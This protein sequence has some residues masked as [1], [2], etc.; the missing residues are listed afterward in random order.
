MGLV[1]C[2]ALGIKLSRKRAED[3][4]TF[5][6]VGTIGSLTK[7]TLAYV[8]KHSDILQKDKYLNK[9][10]EEGKKQLVKCYFDC[11]FRPRISKFEYEEEL[12]SCWGGLTSG[13]SKHTYERAAPD[14]VFVCI[15]VNSEYPAI[16]VKGVPCGPGLKER[17]PGVEGV[18]YVTR[19]YVIPDMVDGEPCKPTPKPHNPLQGCVIA[20]TYI[21]QCINGEGLYV[22]KFLLDDMDEL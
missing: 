19:F 10:V 15:D 17:P 4:N 22:F 5:L 11:I 7:R 6:S 12:R 16:M 14:K 9:L 20:D 3:L 18:D 8:L 13:T 21:K 1:T 2:A